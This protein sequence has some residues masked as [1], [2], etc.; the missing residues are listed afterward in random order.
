MKGGTARDWIRT[1]RLALVVGG[2]GILRGVI[3]LV[4]L[5]IVLWAVLVVVLWVVLAVV[6]WIVS[7]LHFLS[8][9][10]GWGPHEAPLRWWGVLVWVTLLL[11]LWSVN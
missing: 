11:I 4:V 6:L 7:L 10:S 8:V 9:T 2:R 3:W 5:A 1:H